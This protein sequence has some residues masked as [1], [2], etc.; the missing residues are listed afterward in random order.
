MVGNPYRPAALVTLVAK[1]A[2]PVEAVDSQQV[3][4]LVQKLLACYLSHVLASARYL[5]ESWRKEYLLMPPSL[6]TV[7]LELE[8]QSVSAMPTTTMYLHPCQ[9]KPA[10]NQS[11]PS[12]QN[13][14]LTCLR[15]PCT[16]YCL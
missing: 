15:L 5:S 2:P 3:T 6:S 13:R 4:G 16:E 14:A 8:Y 1:E 12:T 11:K 10:R 7:E 9:R